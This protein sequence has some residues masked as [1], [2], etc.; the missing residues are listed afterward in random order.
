M[1]YYKVYTNNY[2]PLCIVKT[3]KELKLKELCAHLDCEHVVVESITKECYDELAR[4]YN[5]NF[6]QIQF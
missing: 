2:V 4:L 5:N 3:D 1:K 6:D